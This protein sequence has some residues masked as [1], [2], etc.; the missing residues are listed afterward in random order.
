LSTPEPDPP[1]TPRDLPGLAAFAGLGLTIA[2]TLGV[3]V[4]LGLWAD[5]RFSSSPVCLIVGIVLGCA[6]AVAS[7]V[8]MAKRYL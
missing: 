4:V 2:V 5:D 3:F 8:A 1:S 6:A 7:T